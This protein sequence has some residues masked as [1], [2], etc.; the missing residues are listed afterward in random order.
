M[1]RVLIILFVFVF[2]PSLLFSKSPFDRKINLFPPSIKVSAVP[3]KSVVIA[4]EE[5][6]FY[7]SVI[8]EKGWH[9]YSLFPFEGSEMMKTKVVMDQNIFKEQGFWKESNPV[10]IQDGAI[11]RMVKGHK[12]NVEFSRTYLV[13]VELVNKK[14]FLNGKLVVRS[15]DNQVCSFPQKIPF[16][17]LL[18]VKKYPEGGRSQRKK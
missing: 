7:I 18:Q 10:L 1:K 5:F 15:C 17:S 6:K 16:R 11:G 12:G 8:L 3:S 14:Y 9:I 13:P 4:G 2:F